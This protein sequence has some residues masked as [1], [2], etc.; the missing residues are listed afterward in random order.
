[1]AISLNDHETRLK[2]LESFSSPESKMDVLFEDL[3]RMNNT[4]WAYNEIRVQVDVKNPNH[5]HVFVYGNISQSGTLIIDLAI[6]PKLTVNKE[7]CLLKHNEADFDPVTWITKLSD[8]S[9]K[10]RFEVYGRGSHRGEPY[11]IVSIQL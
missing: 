5:T 10:L 11:R 6:L 9:F 8:R 7:T 4:N 2:H 1:M 3:S